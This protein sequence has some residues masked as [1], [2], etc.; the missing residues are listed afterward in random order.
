MRV[1]AGCDTQDTD[2]GGEPLGN[3][4]AGQR[5]EDSAVSGLFRLID[6]FL[7]KSQA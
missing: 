5:P 3:V 6:D 4:R 1:Q 2:A 7:R